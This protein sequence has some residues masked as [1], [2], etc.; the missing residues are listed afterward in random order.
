[1]AANVRANAVSS[2]LARPGEGY[3][4]RSFLLGG[5][6]HDDLLWA[7]LKA[8]LATAPI[9]FELNRRPPTPG[10]AAPRFL[11]WAASARLSSEAAIPLTAAGHGGVSTVAPAHRRP[12]ACAPIYRNCSVTPILPHS[13]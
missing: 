1:M 7:L 13:A 6:Y 12:C 11:T 3:L 9:G 5:Q 2:G 4:R 8:G 10:T